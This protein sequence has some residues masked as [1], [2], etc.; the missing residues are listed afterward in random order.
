M[1]RKPAL[2]LSGPGTLANPGKQEGKKRQEGNPAQQLNGV[3]WRED[4]VRIRPPSSRREWLAG[5]EEDK[6]D[7]S[8]PYLTQWCGKPSLCPFASGGYSSAWLEPQ[9]V[10]LAVAGSNPVGHPSL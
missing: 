9:I 8:T 10:D 1:N 7:K 2:D 3:A 6:S 5:E 4:D